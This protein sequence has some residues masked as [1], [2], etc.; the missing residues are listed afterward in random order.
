[1]RRR[2]RRGLAEPPLG[3][4]PESDVLIRGGFADLDDLS[5]KLARGADPDPVAAVA[6]ETLRFFDERGLEGR[7]GLV[8]ARHGRSSTT[9][10]VVSQRLADRPKVVDV[11]GELATRLGVEVKPQV[12]RDHDVLLK[13]TGIRRA[14]FSGSPVQASAPCLLLRTGLLPDRRVLYVN[15]PALGHVLVSGRT[16]GAVATTMSSLLAGL[17]AVRR[18]EE[19]QVL[20]VARERA[21]PVALARL[22]HLARGWAD[23]A[24]DVTAASVL[25]DLRAE[26]L[27]R[28]ERVERGGSVE[29][30]PELVLVVPELD[31]LGDHAATLEMLGAYG[32]RHR[33]RMLAGTVR[34]ADVSE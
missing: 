28:M 8:A 27:R 15:W 7:V 32:P 21:L 29:T 34:P 30:L 9:L 1:V 18:P 5:R 11:A 17:V 33:V 19:L 22:P 25:H 4:E 10:A 14:R 16:R 13:M 26:L 12:S 6:A 2:G 3:D 24:D 31:G 20:I 23:P